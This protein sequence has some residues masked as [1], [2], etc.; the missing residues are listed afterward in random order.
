MEP[1]SWPRSM[2]G[3][4]RIRTPVVLA[5]AQFSAFL[6]HKV[7]QYPLGT[8]GGPMDPKVYEVLLSFRLWGLWY[9]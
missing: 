1:Q 3:P 4:D 5:E 9:L 7:P 8:S 2:R 6:L